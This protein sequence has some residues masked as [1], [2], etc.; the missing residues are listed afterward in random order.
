MG[1]SEVG[2]EMDCGQA[3][4]D[5]CT[6]Y[7]HSILFVC[8]GNICRSPTAEGVLQQQLQRRG[9]A[10]RV[11]VDSAGT[12]DYHVGSPPDERSQVHARRRGYELGAL[13]ARLLVPQ[14]FSEFDLILTMDER[15]FT[16][17]RERCPAALRGRIAPI[18]R[19]FQRSRLAEVPDPYYGGPEGFEVVLDLLEDAAAGLLAHMEAHLGATPQKHPDTTPRANPRGNHETELPGPSGARLWASPKASGEPPQGPLVS[20]QKGDV[21]S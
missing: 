15:N 16:L 7:E 19:F 18:S 11:R 17:A 9:W 20:P 14:D 21:R 2:S 12:H 8:M 1:R 13:R 4:S 10:A 6:S 3:V 5:G